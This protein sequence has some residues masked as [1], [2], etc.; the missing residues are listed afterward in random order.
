M[1]AFAVDSVLARAAVLR[2]LALGFA[3]PAPGHGAR[4]RRALADLK[5]IS[6]AGRMSWRVNAALLT[7]R[8]A[9]RDAA[10]PALE[11]HYVRLFLGNP[12]C[13][14]NETAYG[15]GRR[16]AGRAAELADIAGFYEAFGLRLSA[17]DPDL[18]DHLATELE[19]LSLLL[20]KLAYAGCSGWTQRRRASARA[21]AFFLDDHLGR[22]VPAFAA[23]LADQAAPYPYRALAALL[24]TAIEGEC[25]FFRVRPRPAAGR[26]PG[27]ELQDE[28][29]ACPRQTG[30]IGPV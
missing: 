16:I 12:A 24:A 9:W 7:A 2:A 13:P 11:G 21:A 27:D 29:F 8:R 19:F 15:D 23:G 26:L 6:G 25:R 4:V 28:P 18:P 22:W 30:A 14:L 20:V 10:E 3:Y 5:E 17:T 1:A